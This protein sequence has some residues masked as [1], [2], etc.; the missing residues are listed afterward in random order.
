MRPS[1]ALDRLVACG[2]IPGYT[3]EADT[4]Y[5]DADRPT[6]TYR[7]Y[8][9]HTTSRHNLDQFCSLMADLGAELR[10]SRLLGT[11]AGAGG[12]L[13]TQ[14]VC[15]CAVFADEHMLGRATALV[16]DRFTC[17]PEAVPGSWRFPDVRI[18]GGGSTDTIPVWA[19]RW[20]AAV[21]LSLSPTSPARGGVCAGVRVLACWTDLLTRGVSPSPARPADRARPLL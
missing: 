2:R 7:M 16:K 19:H 17:G 10:A 5:L 20:G 8:A 3:L 1:D 6:L 13:R 9:G 4:S 15:V 11:T 14:Q 12:L 18:T 21:T